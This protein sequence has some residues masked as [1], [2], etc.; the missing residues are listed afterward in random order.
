M[1]PQR[2]CSTPLG[3][4]VRARV[5]TPGRDEFTV[6][7]ELQ[8]EVDREDRS[9]VSLRWPGVLGAHGRQ[10]CS[11]AGHHGRLQEERRALKSS[12]RGGRAFLAAG[13]GVSP[14]LGVK[15]PRA[16]SGNAKGAGVLGRD[17]DSGEGM[18]EQMGT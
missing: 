9:A 12:P 13:T 6:L 17:W 11:L 7:L 16:H 8:L 3:H 1:E 15:R 14:N 10:R 2:P 5:K 4:T 18:S